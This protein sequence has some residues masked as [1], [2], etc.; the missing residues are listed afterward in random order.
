MPACFALLLC[1]SSS[2]SLVT[3]QLTLPTSYFRSFLF[4]V[5]LAV[6]APST[7]VSPFLTDLCPCCSTLSFACHCLCL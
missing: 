5:S 7:S 2:F 6:L 1:L 3:H 4:F